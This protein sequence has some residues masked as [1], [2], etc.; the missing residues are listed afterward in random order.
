MAFPP[1][2]V[3]PQAIDSDYTLYLVYNTTETKLSADNAPWSQEISI[4]PVAE[5]KNEI[6]ANNGFA[7]IDGELLYY[8]SVEKDSNGKVSKLKGCARQLGGKTKNNKKGTWIRGYVV[9]EHHNQIVDC[10]LKTQNFIGYNFDPRVE[11][12]DWRIRNLQELDVIFDDYNCPDVNFTFNITENSPTNG[13]LTEYSIE[14]TPPGSISNFRLDF[15]DGEF[16]TT[17]LEGT[18][19]YAINAR[20]DPVVRISND[21]CQII[22]T[23]VERINPAEP[24]SQQNQVFDFVV[25]EIPPVPEFRFVPCEV[26]EPEINLPPLVVPCISIEGQIG[27]IPSVIVG[28]TINMVS[29]VVITSNNPVQILH[30]VVSI[31]G[32][33]LPSIIIIDPP[34]PPTII[35]IGP[36]SNL[37]VELDFVNA[38]KL[39]VD[40]GMPPAME[41]ALTL[42]KPVSSPERFAADAALMEEFGPEFS[43]LFEL[44][45]TVQVEY[46]PVGIPS[47]IKVIL[48][49]DGINLN[50]NDLFDKKI[51]IDTS[52]VNIPTNIFI[53][54][55]DSPIP[56]SIKFDATDLIEAIDMLKNLEPL[57]ID[58]TDLPTIKLQVD[59]PIP[60]K[61]IVEMVKPIPETITLIGPETIELKAPNSIPLS[62]PEGIGVPLILPENFS[63]PVS[64]SGAPIEVKI[65][66]DKLT[67]A[68]NDAGSCV[69]IVPCN[70]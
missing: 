55:P 69:K 6:W 3:F 58:K 32:G 67:E 59:D 61:I 54:G 62:I 17:E 4:V 5:D 11:T 36:P 35:I 12:L 63:V 38:P 14:V 52:D 45:N 7:N 39:E 13:I 31:I 40:W 47:E 49:E 2:C 26:P 19:R 21:K 42:A 48:P 44:S 60:E 50:T 15:G 46:E 65:T 1:N 41:V 27:P 24:V 66:M 16:T 22:Q 57:K 10:I 34:I 23:P 18:H 28:P 25:P 43:D 9:A 64:W 68:A 53:H 33:D 20:I 70:G 8:D 51:K 29:N 37:A 30:S 56:N